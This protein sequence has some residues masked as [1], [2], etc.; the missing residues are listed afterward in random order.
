MPRPL[1]LAATLTATLF[2]IPAAVRAESSIGEPGSHPEWL[3]EGEPHGLLS[4]WG[5]PGPYKG[6]GFGPGVRLSVVILQNGFIP[7]INNSVAIGA[8]FDW[9]HYSIKDECVFTLGARF[10]PFGN[11]MDNFLVPIVLQ[12]NFF[13]SEQWSVFAEPGVGIRFYDH[14]FAYDTHTGVDPFIFFAGGRFHFDPSVT[15]TV[16]VGWPYLSAGVSFL[17]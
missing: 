11:N 2:L 7:S 3:I 13:F 8:G 9:I 10:C 6:L 16:R 4:P 15:L 12:W 17:I 5:P 14:Y 1:R